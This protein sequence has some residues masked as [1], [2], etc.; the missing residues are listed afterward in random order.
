MDPKE[1][2]NLIT[3]NPPCVE[4]RDG[5]AQKALTAAQAILVCRQVFLHLQ[6]GSSGNSC[7]AHALGEHLRG[8]RQ[9]AGIASP[10]CKTPCQVS[11]VV[12]ADDILT[13]LNPA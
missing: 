3:G 1:T 12:T 13:Q 8:A 4:Q 7:A 9:G 11:V 10:L 5:C 6:S 2:R